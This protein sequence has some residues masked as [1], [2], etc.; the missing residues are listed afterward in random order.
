LLLTLT[1]THVTD[2]R[3]DRQTDRR[4]GQ[5]D[6]SKRDGIYAIACCILSPVRPSV[7]LLHV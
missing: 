4:A 5:T 7:R 1:Q 3:T 2:E 6:H